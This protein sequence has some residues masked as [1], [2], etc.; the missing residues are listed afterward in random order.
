MNTR[1][2]E[3]YNNLMAISSSHR[4]ESAFYY[5]DQDVISEKNPEKYQGWKYR[6]FGYMLASYTDFLQPDA[7]WCRGTMFLINEKQE[8]QELTCLPMK[9]FFNLGET[10]IGLVSDRILNEQVSITE[11][12]DG[13]LMS[14]YIDVDGNLK[15]KSKMSIKSDHCIEAMKLLDTDRYKKLKEYLGIYTN[16]ST[17]PMVEDPYTNMTVDLEW[18]SPNNRIVLGYDTDELTI[19]STQSLRMVL[20]IKSLWSIYNTE[21]IDYPTEWTVKNFW[22]KSILKENKE[23]I[24]GYV[25]ELKDGL[26]VKIKTDWYCLLHKNKEKISTPCNLYEL[27]LNEQAD[28][29]IALFTGDDITIQQIKD[30]QLRAKK[31]YYELKGSCDSFYSCNK[32]LDRKSYAIRGQEMLTSSEFGLAMALYVGKEPDYV[33]ILVKNFI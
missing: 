1:Q 22:D 8:P 5:V 31:E 13:S 7:L 30:M 32:E 15:L 25:V 20:S 18:T 11:K 23:G 14:T 9:K 27:C 24:E 3:L 33:K 19:L 4:S 26:R 6:I 28:D 29:L 12:R 16:I 21:L 17:R 10:P 2:L